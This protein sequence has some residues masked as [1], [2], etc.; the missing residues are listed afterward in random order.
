MVMVALSHSIE[1]S[2]RGGQSCGQASHS[3]AAAPSYA[4]GFLDEA[5]RM[6]VQAH[7]RDQHVDI[8]CG[9]VS[10][11]KLQEKLRATVVVM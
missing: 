11:E 7:N 4:I 10:H 3:I 8:D 9:P 2:L 5:A 1:D 6:E